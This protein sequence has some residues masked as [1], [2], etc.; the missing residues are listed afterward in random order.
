MVAR[1]VVFCGGSARTLGR[2]VE[3]AAAVRAAT[4][5]DDGGSKLVQADRMMTLAVQE[6]ADWLQRHVAATNERT[7]IA[8]A[9]LPGAGK[10]TVTARIAE[11]FNA[12]AGAGRMLALGMDG[13]HLSKKEL[14]RAHG[15]EGMTRRGAPWTFDPAALLERLRRLRAAEGTV[16]WPDFAHDVGDPVADGPWVTAETRV[17]LVEGLYLLLDEPVWRD[18]GASFDLRWYL[19][20]PAAV[21]RERLIRRHMQAWKLDRGAATRRVEAN[22]DHNAAIVAATRDR[23]DALLHEP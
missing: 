4:V 15:P 19:D 12:L 6:V 17:V 1:F 10:T 9:G 21:A 23:A 7:L 13:F 2:E 16:T 14:L 8:L 3:V 20:V 11:R 18:V 5:R 22:D